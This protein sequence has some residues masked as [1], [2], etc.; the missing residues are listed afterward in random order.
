[1]DEFG[2]SARGG[3]TEQHIAFLEV[4]SQC[5]A[6]TALDDGAERQTVVPGDGPQLAAGVRGQL[7]RDGLRSSVAQV[8]GTADQGRMTDRRQI[9]PPE[10]QR[11]PVVSRSQPPEVV[12][13]PGPLDRLWRSAELAGDLG[14]TPPVQRRVVETQDQAPPVGCP[15]GDEPDERTAFQVEAPVAVCGQAIVERQ[16]PLD[17]EVRLRGGVD[18]LD[19]GTQTPPGESRPEAVVAPDHRRPCVRDVV[20]GEGTIDQVDLLHHV[21]RRVRRVRFLAQHAR[22]QGGQRQELR[23]TRR[24]ESG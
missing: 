16:A 6:P 23:Y 3:D 2:R 8:P 9:R 18:D 12:A 11:G 17:G 10:V 15:M 4:V 21:D 22:L 13:V 19:G 20:D 1:M 7:P 24:G 14:C 5:H